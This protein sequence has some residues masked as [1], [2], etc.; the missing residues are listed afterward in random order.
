MGADSPI[1]RP[2]A[3]SMRCTFT[4]AASPATS[5]RMR[6]VRC[7]FIRETPD[8]SAT[9]L[10]IGESTPIALAAYQK[11]QTN[12]VDLWQLLGLPNGERDRMQMVLE[13]LGPG[14]GRVAGILTQ[15]ANDGTNATLVT[16]FAP[17]GPQSPGIGVGR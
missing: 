12:D 17:A 2:V 16:A 13:S 5:A 11:I 9:G 4:I 10:Q 15:I 6:F 3:P 7:P 1:W 8:D 14:S